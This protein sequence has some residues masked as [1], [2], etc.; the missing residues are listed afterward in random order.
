MAAVSAAQRLGSCKQ[1]RSSCGRA[2]HGSRSARAPC[3]HAQ[4][5]GF[6][7]P[8]VLQTLITAIHTL[9]HGCSSARTLEAGDA[10]TCQSPFCVA[11]SRPLQA[12]HTQM[13][14]TWRAS[15]LSMAWRRECPCHQSTV[16]SQVRSRGSDL[17]GHGDSPTTA[18]IASQAP[19]SKLA[20]VSTCQQS[21][22]PTAS[23]KACSAC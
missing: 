6:N 22:L 4:P 7:Q 3:Y 12:P 1:R 20:A 13:G 10:V 15:A 9:G 8:P 2:W 19:S 14:C 17:G 18:C 21:Q 23:R 11:M 16:H 5:A